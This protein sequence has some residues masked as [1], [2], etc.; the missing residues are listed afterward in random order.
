MNSKLCA[1][2]TIKFS[3]QKQLFLRT[4]SKVIQQ[5]LCLNSIEFSLYPHSIILHDY[6]QRQKLLKEIIQNM[7]I[8][9]CPKFFRK[10]IFTGFSTTISARISAKVPASGIFFECIPVHVFFEIFPR[11]FFLWSSPEVSQTV[12]RKIHL[13]SFLRNFIQELLQK[14]VH[15]FLQVVFR[16]CLKEAFLQE[17][18]Q[19]FLLR[20]FY[21]NSCRN[22]SR[23]FR[24][25][26]RGFSSKNFFRRCYSRNFFSETYLS[27]GFLQKFS[28]CQDSFRVS[29]EYYFV[30]S[31][32]LSGLYLEISMNNLFELLREE[33]PLWV[34][35]K[36]SSWYVFRQV[37]PS[38]PF[39]RN[40]FGFFFRRY[41]KSFSKTLPVI[42]AAI[43]LESIP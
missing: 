42:S 26:S 18:Y 34:F 1:A 43:A 22:F 32:I 2:I 21:R 33:V 29:S 38:T 5:F 4:Q 20:D 9:L 17:Y 19:N 41:F 37:P 14:F 11:D 25:F 35:S 13:Q 31:G 40:L 30:Y 36:S 10:Q 16:T 12:S 15:A 23:N 27:K 7:Y 8:K 28:F 24:N 39:F 3:F 6:L